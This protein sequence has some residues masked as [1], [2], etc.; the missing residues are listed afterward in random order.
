MKKI[1]SFLLLSVSIVV[2]QEHSPYDL[3]AVKALNVGTNSAGVGITNFATWVSDGLAVGGFQTNVVYTNTAGNQ[4]RG[5]LTQLYK[6]APL[7]TDRN[8]Q[9]IVQTVGGIV[10][11]IN[12]GGASASNYLALTSQSL[13]IEVVNPAANPSNG[14]IGIVLCPL[15]YGDTGFGSTNANTDW[16]V[17]LPG[18]AKRKYVVST[19]VPTWRWPGA[20]G[21]AV[22][23]ITN[24]TD[25]GGAE[26]LTNGTFI[27]SMKLIGFRP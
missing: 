6:T 10:A 21:L 12:I 19:N 20:K 8:G 2:G 16:S 24:Q 22:R 9:P 7:F 14:P 17:I 27:T 25:I 23:Y 18:F 5:L 13:V 1:L 15:W 11:G 26:A 3:L 4:V